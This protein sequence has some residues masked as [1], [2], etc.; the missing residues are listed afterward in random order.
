MHVHAA[1]L[2]ATATT[3]YSS[4]EFILLP[5]MWLLSHGGVYLKKLWWENVVGQKF[6]IHIKRDRVLTFTNR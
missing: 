5:I 1:Y 3:L 4:A 6:L 2:L